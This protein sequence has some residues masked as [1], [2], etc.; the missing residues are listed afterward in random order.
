MCL[1]AFA[2]QVHPD[3]PLILAA[4]RDEFYERPTTAAHFWKEEEAPQ[5]LAGKDLEAGGTWMGVHTSRKW[6]ALTNYRDPSITREN[7]P[8]RGSIIPEYLL[9]PHDAAEYVQT[10]RS[11]SNHF[12]GF[13][14]L[15]GDLDQLFHY[16]NTHK[17]IT[18]VKAGIHGVSNATLNTSWPKLD[19]AKSQLEKNILTNQLEPNDFFS[20]LT[21]N[22]EAEDALLPE[23][24]IPYKWEKAVSSVF[25]KTESYGTRCSTILLIDKEGS[26]QFTE[27]RYVPQS[28]QIK[29]E[30]TFRF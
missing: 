26:I 4:N 11:H 6:A 25:I 15:L 3:Y 12:M 30:H 28:S 19:W 20:W 23:T 21:N 10:L 2:Y 8:S 17:I 5:L 1:I 14:V 9:S 18:P 24:G 7:P 16:S 27:R 13:N 22:E 29:E